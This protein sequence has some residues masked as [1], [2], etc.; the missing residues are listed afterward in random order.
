MKNKFKI[1]SESIFNTLSCLFLVLTFILIIVG[2]S[3]SQEKEDNIYSHFPALKTMKN[4]TLDQNIINSSLIHTVNSS[5][6]DSNNKTVLS[7][8]NNSLQQDEI[9]QLKPMLSKRS[10]LGSAVVES[11]IYVVGGISDREYLNSIERYDPLANTWENL[12]SMTIPRAGAAVTSAYGKLYVIGGYNSQLEDI[13]SVEMYDPATNTWTVKASMTNARS[14]HGAATLNGKIYVVGGDVTNTS[15]EVY[16]PL[17]DSWTSSASIPMQFSIGKCEVINGKLYAIGNN[18]STDIFVMEYDP[19]SNIWTS[20]ENVP[21]NAMEFATAVVNN[22]IYV[23]GG[24]NELVEGYYLSSVYAYDPASD[25]WASK[26]QMPT[27]RNWLSASSINGS[28]FVIGGENEK[29]PLNLVEKFTPAEDST[30]Q[31]QT[32]NVNKDAINLHF[33]KEGVNPASGNFTRNYT[34]MSIFCPGFQMNISRIYN[35]LDEKVGILGKGW[36]FGFEGSI[37]DG[38]LSSIKNITLPNGSKM[39][40]VERQDGITYDA[41]DSHNKLG[42]NQDGTFTLTTSDN[43]KY[44]FNSNRYLYLMEDKYGN[45]IKL[46]LKSDG[47]VLKISDITGRYYLLDYCD[48]DYLRF[49]REYDNDVA[50]GRV[51][52]Y[53]YDNNKLVKV[54]N[55][56]GY[57]THYAYDNDGYL[58]E[59]KDNSLNRIEYIQYINTEG[60]NKKKINSITDALGNTHNYSYDNSSAKTIITDL[61]GIQTINYYD[62]NLY[63]TISIDAEGRVSKTE[64]Y[65]ENDTN[66]YGDIKSITNRNGNKTLY[67]TDSSGNITKIINP[68]SSYKEFTYDE[69]NNKL[70]ERDELGNYTFYVYDPNKINI[71]IKAQ[72]IN[73]TDIY[74][75]GCDESQFIITRYSYYSDT[76]CAKLGYKAKGL[77]KSMTDP[78]N[79]SI[80]YTYHS[81][82]NLKTMTDP[83]TGKVTSYAYNVSGLVTSKTSPNHIITEYKYDKLN[84]VEKTIIRNQDNTLNSVTRIIYDELGRKKQV[85]APNLFTEDIQDETGYRYTYYP[86]GKTKSITDPENNCTSYTYDL[87]G[88]ILTEIRPNKSIFRYEYDTMNRIV[89]K[90]FKE[91]S[92]SKEETLLEQY[93]YS[94]LPDGNSKT[95]Y[96]KNLNENESAI[97]VYIYDYANRL[98]EL[99]NADD[100]F[101]R[102]YYNSNGS[103]A[104]TSDVNNAVTYFYYDRLNRLEHKYTPYEMQSGGNILYSHTIFR[105]DNLGRKISEKII[106]E[107]DKV[108]TIKNYTYYKNSLLKSVSDEAGR[109]TDYYYDS[110]GNMIREDIFTDNINKNT[111]EYVYNYLDKLIAKKVHVSS[112]DIYGY[113]VSDTND[114]ILETNYT[115]DKN[116]NLSSVK[117]PDGFVTEYQYDNLDRC[118]NTKYQLQNETGDIVSITESNTYNWEG[119]LLTAID[120]NNNVTNYTYDPRGFL[121]NII[122]NVK[123]SGEEIKY[124]N[125][126]FYDTAG[127]KVKEVS[128]N[129]YDATKHIDEMNRTEFTYDKMNRIK[130]ITET[131][132]DNESGKWKS[133]VTKAYIYDYYGNIKKEFDAIGYLNGY[134]R[135]Y[136]YN[137][138]NKLTA[139][140]EDNVVIQ[141]KYD[142]LGRK[143][144]EINACG[145]ETSTSYDDVG[146]ITEIKEDGKRIQSYTYDLAGR[147][148]TQTDGN[149][150]TINYQYNSINLPKYI[151]LPG[152]ETI[153]SNTITKQYDVL[154]R[155]KAE[156]D[157][158]GKVELYSYDNNN[159]VITYV[160]QSKDGSDRIAFYTRYDVNGNKRYESD[161]NGNLKE[162]SYDDLNRLR[163]TTVE[164]MGEKQTS[165]YT[166]DK[167]GN[168]VETKDWLG[169]T[170]TYVYDP[171]D[172][173]IEKSDPYTIIQKLSYNDNNLQIKS[174]DA[175]GN[176]TSYQYDYKNRLISTTDP[177]GNVMRYEYDDFGNI[178]RKIDG[179]MQELYYVYDE[180]NRL[181]YISHNS[182]SLITYGYDLNRNMIKQIDGK[183][184]TKNY[185]YNCRNLI[186]KRIDPLGAGNP[187]KT[188]SY[189]YY[190]NGL[191]KTKM[192]RNGKLTTY[193]YDIHGRLISE[194]IGME[195]ITYTYDANGNQLT[196]TD[197][198]GTTSRTYDE[199]N[200]VLTKTVPLIGTSFYTYDIRT[201]LKYGVYAE[202]SID[203]KGNITI[204]EFDKAGRLVAVIA[205]EKITKYQYNSNGSKSGVIYPDGSRAEFTY[206]KNGNN[207]TITNINSKGLVVE[208]Y[209]YSYDAANNLIQK[210]DSKGYT[211]YTYDNMNRIESIT[212]PSGKKTTY[213]YDNSGN[214]ETESIIF[215]NISTTINYLYNEQ[216][217]LQ[218]VKKT[219]ENGKEEDIYYYYDNNGNLTCKVNETL[220]PINEDEY[221]LDANTSLSNTSNVTFYNYDLWNQLAETHQGD[222]HAYYKYNAEGFRVEKL[223]NSI[224]TRYLYEYDRVVLEVDE[225][226]NQIGKNVYGTNLLTRSVEQ[227]TYYYMYNGHGDV[228]ALISEDGTIAATYYYDA[229]GNIISETGRADNNVKYS[230]YQHDD[231]TGLYYLN[232]RYYDSTIARFL[233]EDTYQGQANDP[234]SLNLYTYCVNNPITYY[235]PTGHVIQKGSSGASVKSLQTLLT[236]AGYDCG[237]IDGKFG[238]KT[239]AAIIKY[240]KDNKLK[241]D[242]IVGNQT[243]TSLKQ[244]GS[245]N[246]NQ[247]AN[248]PPAKPQKNTNEVDTRASD[249]KKTATSQNDLIADYKNSNLLD[250]KPTNNNQKQDKKDVGTSNLANASG[251]ILVVLIADDATVVGTVDDFLIPIVAVPVVAGL[252]YRV[253]KAGVKAGVEVVRVGT[254]AIVNFF[255]GPTTSSICVEGAPSPCPGPTPSPVPTPGA[256]VK[257]ET[258]KGDSKTKIEGRGHSKGGHQPETLKEELAVEEVMGNPSAGKELKGLNNDT[259]WK[260]S[261]GWVKKSQNINGVEVHYEYNP[262]TGQIDDI[263][264]K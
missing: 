13:N 116:G 238:S 251:A 228:T 128:P 21:I 221:V 174:I 252:G 75:N 176:E 83:E 241:V 233:T 97:T 82:G 209:K 231:E 167:N 39:T 145:G 262:M 100:S 31:D 214:R 51:I 150:N 48:T 199:K 130:T 93:S 120:P 54:V 165:Y 81:D 98:I 141:Y 22:K 114:L 230:G 169:N 20:K 3:F 168:I 235:D 70:S 66:K 194:T 184:N 225:K 44:T 159:N 25:S 34:D 88:N 28:M 79:N 256:T 257:G 61:N 104:R 201:N 219:L 195:T 193:T 211:N 162:Y 198:T 154:G 134:W 263:K 182:K 125:A 71:L 119:N 55:P 135:G 153:P 46:E 14:N 196:V 234:L 7:T 178:E 175:L 92:S 226:G 16:N 188:E 258:S 86:S 189:H 261:E 53:I 95:I 183:E 35:S 101:Q 2:I 91:N 99:Q 203:P 149:G 11:Q 38:T 217:R 118:T 179:K 124:I 207:Q 187:D 227:D 102:Y 232:A 23:V 237:T 185:Q 152:D 157:S 133:Y 89:K 140:C 250:T 148:L 248:T 208:K 50:T 173:L 4:E 260:A 72:P 87:Y 171:I 69:K 197:S 172:R 139:V 111:K 142:C 45:Y 62:N 56:L 158:V 254:E 136:E 206:A 202:S 210:S 90:Y 216:N 65:H 160:E 123:N 9:T 40:F 78:L 163:S 47:K 115:Y 239:Q 129:N 253:V 17:T 177:V 29:N 126:F 5:N 76:E 63:E 8:T 146:N 213:T 255:T 37:T 121:K 138:M 67:E 164:V 132:C 147:M 122:Y 246:N 220:N 74:Y 18:C 244:N 80:E 131:Y 68:D 204:K 19:V 224:I 24:Y 151:K 94:I 264:I 156:S 15:V 106:D 191:L 181:F 205:D 242:G 52:E 12:K 259:R 73:G 223:V 42:K 77:L 200:R 192:D 36:S 6:I 229:F 108:Y 161:A 127:R 43:Y 57:S 27:A 33:G 1:L 113:D 186:V 41:V 10:R 247:N 60:E 218:C 137:L 112:G 249:S 170:Y 105:Y 180:Y 96:T 32:V 26:T 215:N 143:V 166:Y 240:Q 236:Q 190:A 117:A 144:S 64:Y 212:E 110:D 222:I 107:K 59:I 103:I 58:S 155:L 245:K 30:E 109:K 85:I 49:V 84:N 243:L